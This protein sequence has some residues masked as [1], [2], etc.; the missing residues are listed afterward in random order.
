MTKSK[1][2]KK[3]PFAEKWAIICG[4]SKGIGKATAKE[5]VK[6][7]GNVCIVA[8]TLEALKKAEE[9]ISEYKVRKIQ[10][11]EIISC[12][13]TD[14]EKLKPLLIEFID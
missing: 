11:V 1:L 3:Q 12:D 7:G 2:L 6:L 13:T 8:R 4:G 5:I 9:E 14:Q 10:K